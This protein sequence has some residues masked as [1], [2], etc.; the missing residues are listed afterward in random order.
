M[1]TGTSIEEL[2][3]TSIDDEDA[4]EIWYYDRVISRPK[5]AAKRAINFLLG[6]HPDR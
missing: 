5:E 4:F 1:T 6:G 3:K 2:L